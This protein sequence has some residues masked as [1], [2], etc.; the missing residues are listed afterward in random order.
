MS[1]A[2]G[3]ANSGGTATPNHIVLYISL[4]S[5]QLLLLRYVA[6]GL[7]GI[8]LVE[9]IGRRSWID[10]IIAGAFW[11]LAR[12]VLI[13]V[14][15][16]L[17]GAD[18]HAARLLPHGIVE[19]A[20]WILVSI[21]AGFVEELTFRGYLQHQFAAWTHSTL[22]AVIVQAVVF[23]A[24]H[25]YQGLKSMAIVAIYGALFGLLAWWRRSLVPGMLAHA[26]TDIFSGISG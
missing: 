2:S 6:I 7:Q 8:T 12:Y 26:W 22:A 4:I 11:L 3:R 15:Q 18:S 20:L 25:G 23:G 17:G 9:L 16:L 19:I 21:A 5:A 14:R 24:S 10:V 1:A 13:F